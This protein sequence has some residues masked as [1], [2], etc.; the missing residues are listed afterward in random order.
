M[1]L[2]LL[3][4][5]GLHA[6]RTLIHPEVGPCFAGEG[7]YLADEMLKA[8][9]QGVLHL[10]SVL[11]TPAAAEKYSN[12]PGEIR[13]L[14]LPKSELQSLV[15][16]PFNRGVIALAGIPTE[17]DP[18]S[19]VAI[20]RLL[21]LPRL[22][23]AEN[24]GALLRTAVALGMEGVLVGQ[25]P[26]P[27]VTRALRVSMGA[28][29]R[30]PLWHREDALPLLRTWKAQGGEVVGAALGPTSEVASTWRPQARTALLLGAEDQGLDAPWL[31]ACD[32]LLR[33]PMQGDMDSLNVGAAGAILMARLTGA[34]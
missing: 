9:H 32:R 10:R 11:A 18:E 4:Y 29:W 33:I 25:G 3:P 14:V 7:H 19:L 22:D 27:F 20:H 5:R 1:D 26:S 30:I 6:D 17:P 23:N 16:F 21:V 31:S 8:H 2:E 28:A 15:G 12:L 24:L 34:L 13:L